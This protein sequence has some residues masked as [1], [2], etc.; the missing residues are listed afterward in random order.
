MVEDD[1]RV[2]RVA[3]RHIRQLGFSTLEAENADIAKTMI[4]SG[5][6]IDLLFSDIMMPGEINGKQLA[7]W[8]VRHHPHIQVILAS[9]FVAEESDSGSKALQGPPVLKK[10]YSA[11]DISRV[12]SHCE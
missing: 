11:A 2:R 3:L 8:V 5:E 1:P 10:P 4:E 9:G 6:N 7:G 12:L